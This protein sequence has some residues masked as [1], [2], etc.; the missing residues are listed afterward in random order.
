L[1]TATVEHLFDPFFTTKEERL[2]MGL[3]IS[4]SIVESHGGRLV[5]KPNDGPGATFQFT[6]PI[7]TRDIQGEMDAANR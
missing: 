2:G 5:A 4:Y 7:E 6:L 3:A 1:D